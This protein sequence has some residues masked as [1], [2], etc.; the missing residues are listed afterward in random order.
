MRAK[1]AKSI[2]DYFIKQRLRRELRMTAL[3]FLFFL[4]VSAFLFYFD[5]YIFQL[6]IMIGF[7]IFFLCHSFTRRNRIIN[8]IHLL[9]P[10]LVASI[11]AGW[12]LLVIGNDIFQEHLHWLVR[13]IIVIIVF[14][15]ILYENNKTLPN[16]ST[17]TKICRAI[18]LMLIS[19]S[20]SLI[21]GIFA[22]DVLG[23]N[24]TNCVCQGQ[25]SPVPYLWHF[26]DDSKEL[27][28][29]VFPEYIIQFSFLAMFNGVFIQM[30]F[31][32]KSIT[33]I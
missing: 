6:L 18:Q 28:L 17:G 20:I 31:E 3:L 27:T 29:N 21:V 8:N 24:I 10:R 19:Y 4:G 12:I 1:T 25:Q 22:M 9:L 30:I 7:F 13:P 14:T 11:T 2:D 16:I 5:N 26:L 15:F 23:G 32:E 33:E